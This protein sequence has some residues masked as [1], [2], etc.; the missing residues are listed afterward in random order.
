MTIIQYNDRITS[1]IYPSS[2]NEIPTS[3]LFKRAGTSSKSSSTASGSATTSQKKNSNG[4]VIGI[5]VGV[6]VGVVVILLLVILFI[7]YKRSK[8]EEKE[9]DDPEFAGDLTYMTEP[10]P[11][12]MKHNDYSSE[13]IDFKGTDEKNYGSNNSNPFSDPSTSLNQ[14]KNPSFVQLPDSI[15]SNSIR[16]YAK[17]HDSLIGGYN[18]VSSRN[19]SSLS[20]LHDDTSI[21]RP[22]MS[23]NNSNLNIVTTSTTTTTTTLDAAAVVVATISSHDGIF[24]ETKVDQRAIIEDNQRPISRIDNDQDKIYRLSINTEEEEVVERIK[25]V[26]KV[27]LE[28]DTVED[29]M[30]QISLDFE[31]N[32]Y[33]HPTLMND[34]GN[35]TVETFSSS[36]NLMDRSY[37]ESEVTIDSTVGSDGRD[38]HIERYSKATITDSMLAPLDIGNSKDH[39]QLQAAGAAS[40]IASSIYSEL[41]NLNG[42]RISQ[43][44]SKP[45]NVQHSQNINIYSPQFPNMTYQAHDNAYDTQRHHQQYLSPINTQPIYS[46]NHEQQFNHP[47]TLESIEELPTPTQ[48]KLMPSDSIHSLTSFKDKQRNQ[49]VQLNTARLHGTALNPMDHPEMFYTQTSDSQFT[50]QQQGRSY[51]DMSKV[52]VPKPYQLRQSIV[53]T[54]PSLLSMTGRYKPA[55]SF[56]NIH[57]ANSR[58]NS[59]VSQLHPS[60]QAYKARVSGLLEFTDVEQPPS[61]GEILPH[62]GT[63]DDLRKQLGSSHNYNVTI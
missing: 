33:P 6:P 42:T 40:R 18:L 47:Q 60:E 17:L 26:Y 34:E 19:N 61:V 63:H 29:K 11:L 55:G 3:T 46:Y 25:S 50:Y 1:T 45:Q 58:N 48:L 8:K 57:S 30:D 35:L 2:I 43:Q 44:I 13:S 27:Y 54:D 38:D 24:N 59:L 49:L 21:N 23:K 32:Q 12:S 37:P 28:S 7:V 5:A 20:L 36:S 22:T 51:G 39:L 15:E 10:K 31:K 41:P 52:D 16:S 56:R 4:E 53:M 9:D 62:S 14:M